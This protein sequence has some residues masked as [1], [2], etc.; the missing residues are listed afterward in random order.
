MHICMHAC[1]YVCPYALTYACTYVYMCMSLYIC[2]Y[3]IYIYTMYIIC[4]HTYIYPYT[5]YVYI[6]VCVYIYIYVYHTYIHYLSNL[7]C[8]GPSCRP[9][10]TR[11]FVVRMIGKGERDTF[12]N[13]KLRKLHWVRNIS[14]VQRKGQRNVGVHPSNA[15]DKKRCVFGAKW[16]LIKHKL[17]KIAWT[18]HI[19]CLIKFPIWCAT[20]SLAAPR[21]LRR[22]FL[23]NDSLR[24]QNSSGRDLDMSGQY[25]IW[26]DLRCMVYMVIFGM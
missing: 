21:P 19:H 17:I 8:K 25:G 13:A 1:M 5:M 24:N 12:R 3:H 2:M 26:C 22:I 14:H 18:L 20:F 10:Y 23:P 4:I 9:S 11:A 6:Y 7:F 15:P 16:N